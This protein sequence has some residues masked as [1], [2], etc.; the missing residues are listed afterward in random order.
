MDHVTACVCWRD[1]GENAYVGGDKG[2]NEYVGERERRR[3]GGGEIVCVGE[4]KR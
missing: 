2:E 1:G 3:K 4:R